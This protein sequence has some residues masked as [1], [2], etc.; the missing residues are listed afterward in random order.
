MKGVVICFLVGFAVF[1]QGQITD[2]IEISFTKS[3][4]LLMDSD[5]FKYDLGS[6]QVSAR[7]KPGNNVLILQ[8]EE[9]FFDET[10]LFIESKGVIYVFVVLYTD[11]PRKSVYNYANMPIYGQDVVTPSSPK[12]DLKKQ[13][14]DSLLNV[15]IGN[16]EQVL[17]LQP[18]VTNVGVKKYKI[19][20]KLVD[21]LV[22]NDKMYFRFRMKNKGNISYLFDYYKFKVVNVK[23]RI[24]GQT[25]QLIELKPLF[26]YKM[27]M[28]IEGK[29]LVD[30]VV[31]FDKFVLTENKKLRIEHW[32]YNG[33]DMSVEGG[34]KINFDIYYR[35]VLNVG[36]IKN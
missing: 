26:T 6:E 15:F 32:E 13:E 23:T 20:I 5:D 8:A 4:Y 22:I 34:R 31:V 30:Y 9:E 18:R 3:A 2:T 7:F 1:C 21:M 11:K 17:R 14:Q 36:S 19:E 25:E 12:V 29:S 24:K 27:P 10:I 35:D 28:K 33:E 16:C